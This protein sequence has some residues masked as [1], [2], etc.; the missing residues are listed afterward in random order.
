MP[1]VSPAEGTDLIENISSF[2]SAFSFL[3]HVTSN[4]D[5]CIT[6]IDGRRH[7]IRRRLALSRYSPLLYIH[8]ASVHQCEG[9]S[10][11]DTY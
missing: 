5:T 7:Y 1:G 9:A 3:V 8:F 10:D 2:C 11:G 6:R 4:P